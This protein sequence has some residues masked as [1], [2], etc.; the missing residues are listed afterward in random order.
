ML[1]DD[2]EALARSEQSTDM[3]PW[4]IHP[5]EYLR[6]IASP[7]ERSMIDFVYHIPPEPRDLPGFRMFT[8]A[9]I[10][11]LQPRDED[12]TAWL[13]NTKESDTL[14][15]IFHTALTN[16]I[17]ELENQMFHIQWLVSQ[18]R[19]EIPHRAGGYQMLLHTSGRKLV[20]VY[21]RMK[22]NLIQP[23]TVGHLLNAQPDI[24]SL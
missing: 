24:F 15:E 1:L 5:E 4:S 13:Y 3:E 11:A 9:Q 7:T 18:H 14:R 16:D 12:L 19:I 21:K 8:I 22:T 2:S 20:D 23:A 6:V 10:F 17:A